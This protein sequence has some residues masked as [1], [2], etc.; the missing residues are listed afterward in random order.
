MWGG[1]MFRTAFVDPTF[2]DNV[3]KVNEKGLLFS[4][5]PL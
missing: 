4:S 5:N 2:H 1:G 3:L